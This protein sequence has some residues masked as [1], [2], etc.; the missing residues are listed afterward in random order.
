VTTFADRGC[1]VVS[2]MDYYGRIFGFLDRPKH[3]LHIYI[4]NEEET[5]EHQPKLQIDGKSVPKV[6]FAQ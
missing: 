4:L 5:R 3:K 1:H 2:V 6:K